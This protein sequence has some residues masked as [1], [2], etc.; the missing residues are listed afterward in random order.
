MNS[1]ARSFCIVPHWERIIKP[2]YLAGSAVV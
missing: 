1:G 2:I